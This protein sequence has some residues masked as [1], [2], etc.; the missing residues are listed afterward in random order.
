MGMGFAKL[1]PGNVIGLT[2]MGGN[3]NSIFSHLHPTVR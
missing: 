1:V 3:E 2:G